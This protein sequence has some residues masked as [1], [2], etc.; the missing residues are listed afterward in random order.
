MFQDWQNLGSFV[1]LATVVFQAMVEYANTERGA[2]EIEA[3]IKD[4]ADDG[5]LN[6]SVETTPND[7]PAADQ[8]AARVRRS[9][10]Q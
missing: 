7:Q 8:P 2:V 3:L 1:K 6:D 10:G 4:F 9:R 5:K